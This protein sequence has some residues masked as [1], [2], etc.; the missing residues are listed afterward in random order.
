MAKCV[1]YRFSINLQLFSV[2]LKIAPLKCITTYRLWD[3]HQMYSSCTS[4][5]LWRQNNPILWLSLAVRI[6]NWVSILWHAACAPTDAKLLEGGVYS[7]MYQE[8]NFICI[9]TKRMWTWYGICIYLCWIKLSESESESGHTFWIAGP[10]AKNPGNKTPT[11]TSLE[12]SEHP[13]WGTKTVVWCHI[14]IDVL[15]KKR[16]RITGEKI[17]QSPCLSISRTIS[18]TLSLTLSLSRCSL[19]IY[20]MYTYIYKYIYIYICV[21]VCVCVCVLDEC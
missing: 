10:H 8:Y 15:Q 1:K 7:I 13:G 5:S 3:S 20:C 2:V 9:F 19:Y 12:Q 4:M 18:L 17:C 11:K 6:P 16:L 14:L 21:C